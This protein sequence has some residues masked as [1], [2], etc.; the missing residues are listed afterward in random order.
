MITSIIVARSLCLELVACSSQT[1][2]RAGCVALLLHQLFPASLL[3]P[4]LR[5]DMICFIYL[6]E[7]RID[8]AIALSDCDAESGERTRDIPG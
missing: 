8:A 7:S 4:P 5:P 1:W 6:P 3:T 2:G